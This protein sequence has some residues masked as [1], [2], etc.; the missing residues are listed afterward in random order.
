MPRRRSE[1]GWVPAEPDHTGEQLNVWVGDGLLAAKRLENGN[2]EVKW[3]KPP[4]P[5]TAFNLGRT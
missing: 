4:G 5:K 2:H 1:S 3:R